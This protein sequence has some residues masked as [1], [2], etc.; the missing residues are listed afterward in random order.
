MVIIYIIAYIKLLLTQIILVRLLDTMD[1]PAKLS[2]VDS[3]LLK[4]KSDTKMLIS[5]TNDDMKIL[6]ICTLFRDWDKKF[7]L[8]NE[9]TPNSRFKKSI[10]D[11]I[12]K[13]FQDQKSLR[14][15]ICHAYVVLKNIKFNKTD[16]DALLKDEPVI[17]EFYSTVLTSGAVL[18]SPVNSKRGL[19]I[20]KVLM[21]YFVIYIGDIEYL[22]GKLKIQGR[23]DTMEKTSQFKEKYPEI[24]SDAFIRVLL[25]S[26]K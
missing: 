13:T 10:D 14:S 6:I 16:I 12:S 7:L 3:I 20:Q 25:N 15:H 23:Y 18:S 22:W 1:H 26:I 19:T 11:Y 21:G 2:K 17:K 4:F 8:F 24:D 9:S 5:M